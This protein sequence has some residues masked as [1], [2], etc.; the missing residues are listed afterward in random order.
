MVKLRFMADFDFK[1][2]AMMTLAYRAGQEAVVT[3]ACA[4]A[5]MARGVAAVVE[6]GPRQG[7]G[8]TIRRRRR[9]AEHG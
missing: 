4:E 5:A 6:G 3:T 8:E 9:K 1:P 7:V 2:S